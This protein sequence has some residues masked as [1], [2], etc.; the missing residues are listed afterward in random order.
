M[1]ALVLTVVAFALS[2]SQAAAEPAVALTTTNA[3][4]RFDTVTPS[5]VSAPI[6][7]TGLQGGATESLQGIAVRPRT[8]G[9]YALGV[10]PGATDT[11]RLYRVSPDTGVATLVNAVVTGITS[12]TFWGMGFNPT[13]DRIRVVNTNDTNIRLNPNN[14][15]LAG[16][17]TPLNPAGSFIDGI[18]YDRNFDR[19]GGTD[20]TL[21][22][23]ARSTPSLVRIGGVDQNPSPNGGAVTLV[24]GLG[25]TPNPASGLGLDIS[26]A[27]GTAYSLIRVGTVTG[28]Y[29]V[30]LTTGAA[31]LVGALG[32]GSAGVR[33]IALLPSGRVVLGAEGKSAVVAFDPAN[34]PGSAFDAFPKGVA[35]GAR[36][37]AGD[38]TR[39]GIPDVIVAAGG[40]TP[41]AVKIFDGKS[42]NFLTQLLAYEANAKVGVQVASGDVDGDG[43]DDVITAPGPGITTEVRVYSGATLRLLGSFTPFGAEYSSGATVA[44]A[45]LNFDGKAEIVVGSGK[46]RL[47]E[48]R[49]FDGT[50]FASLGVIPIAS[51]STKGLSVA[52]A[53][54]VPPVIAV[55]TLTGP[56]DVHVL[57]GSISSG[58]ATFAQVAQFTAYEGS[59]KGVRVALLDLN[60]DSVPEIL[61]VPG[62]NDATCHVFDG[63]THAEIRSFASLD[64]KGAFVAA[65]R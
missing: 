42:G 13:V 27:T 49:V 20:T 3:L 6:A 10:V 47:P 58:V 35:K 25:I 36:V 1:R 43:A 46:G 50:T 32:D 8:G 30:H 7:V 12:G 54:A 65:A 45:D 61:A 57:T 37:A 33:G 19:Q 21:F 53:A 39:D 60:A 14:G 62:G 2:A 16:S 34:D 17:D 28:L 52:A 11:L 40:R 29:T 48:I 24:G 44:A 63:V 31:T 51:E 9:L 55:G 41:T 4:V 56:R 23:I 22:G 38:V 18:A 5:I 59:D 26:T 64:A 15:T